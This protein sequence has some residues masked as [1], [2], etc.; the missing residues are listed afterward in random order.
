MNRAIANETDLID[1]MTTPTPEV[2]E[3]VSRLNGDVIV[4]GVGGNMGPSLVELLVRAGAR[5]VMGSPRF[6]D[7]EHQR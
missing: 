3:A 4:L 2:E 7:S 5:R 1:Q 6:T